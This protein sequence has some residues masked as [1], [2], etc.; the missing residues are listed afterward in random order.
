[1][2]LKRLCF[3]IILFAGFLT[4]E[5][6]TLVFPNY[7]LKSHE[8]LEI[9]RIVTDAKATVLYMSIEN[10][11]EGGT[12]CADKNIYI[13]N[14]MGRRSK[15]VFSSGIPVCPDTH[16][17]RK[18][19]ERLEFTL[20]FPPLAP[21]T[22]YIDLVEECNEDCFSFYGI[23]FDKDLNDK[24]DEAFSMAENGNT[25]GSL[26]QLITI[27]KN[28][29]TANQSPVGLIYINIIKLAADSGESE[30]AEEWYRKFKSEGGAG[31]ARYI[32]FLNDQGIKY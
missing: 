15:L 16:I 12:F 30:T 10:R 2:E 7:A 13:I 6:Q 1:M 18:A 23:V 27:A 9:E 20:T 32:E 14:P 28:R 24:L 31:S 21:G 26:K 4:A 11:I 29:A 19:G 22:E 5:S 17:F 25:S 8:T 3:L